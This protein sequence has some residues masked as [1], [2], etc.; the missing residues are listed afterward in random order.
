MICLLNGVPVT[1]IYTIY[2]N[3]DGSMRVHRDPCAEQDKFV[4]TDVVMVIWETDDL[5]YPG[6]AVQYS[7]L[8]KDDKISEED[9][10]KILAL[11]KDM[12]P[13]INKEVCRKFV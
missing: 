10:E 11:F 1:A 13:E 4:P 12:D 7:A 6:R 8:A 5:D 2:R 3:P 9:L